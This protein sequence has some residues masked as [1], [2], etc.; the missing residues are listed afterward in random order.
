MT[1]EEHRN[2]FS[3]PNTIRTLKSRKVT[4]EET[5]A[6]V[7]QMAVEYLKGKS[8]WKTLKCRLYE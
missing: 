6:S 7:R 8:S 2:L 5:E 3:S 4:Q 1:K